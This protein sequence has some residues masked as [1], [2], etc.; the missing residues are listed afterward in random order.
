[1][2]LSRYS[3]VLLAGKQLRT[4]GSYKKWFHIYLNQHSQRSGAGPQ[5]PASLC[6][7]YIYLRLDHN[8]SLHHLGQSLKEC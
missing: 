5:S 7:Q 4:K 8:L 2:M 1:M 6:G 3:T